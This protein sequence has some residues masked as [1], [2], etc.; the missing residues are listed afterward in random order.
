MILDFL[1]M[2]EKDIQLSCWPKF[3][4]KPL[5]CWKVKLKVDQKLA[6]FG[7]FQLQ[8]TFH[9]WKL[10]I[11]L[12]NLQGRCLPWWIGLF[13]TWMKCLKPFL[14]LIALSW[15]HSW[16]FV[17]LR[18]PWHALISLNLHH[19]RKWLRNETL[20]HTS[21]LWYSSSTN[22]LFIWETLAGRK[23]MIRVD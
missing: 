11:W 2:G 9:F 22:T 20:A 6:V 17:V 21:P 16:L 8:V 19:L 23:S 12:Q 14:H 3:H 15:L 13:R 4:L 7:N 1:E 18:W 10:L 5:W